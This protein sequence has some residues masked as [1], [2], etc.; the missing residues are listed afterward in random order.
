MGYFEVLFGSFTEEN[1]K[2]LS[3]TNKERD[4]ALDGAR[5]RHKATALL[6]G[7][8]WPCGIVLHI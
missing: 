7:W 5:L 3:Q 2:P 8:V 1:K 6:R 4:R